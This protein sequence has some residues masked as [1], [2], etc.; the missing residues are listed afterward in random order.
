MRE[1]IQ[2]EIGQLERS[3][4]CDR[5]FALQL[6]EDNFLFTVL[7]K[8]QSLELLEGDGCQ[9]AVQT[10]HRGFDNRFELISSWSKVLLMK[11]DYILDDAER[12]NWKDNLFQEI[13]NV[14]QTVPTLPAFEAFRKLLEMVKTRFEEKI[15][16]SNANTDVSVPMP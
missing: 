9:S 3:S 10:I 6:L 15:S 7:K 12:K 11:Y 14:I 13:D 16:G 2:F 1:K 8:L 5:L 4:H